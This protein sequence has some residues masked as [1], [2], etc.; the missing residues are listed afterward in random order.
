MMLKVWPFH[1]FLPL[2]PPTR[3]PANIWLRHPAEFS[4]SHELSSSLNTK[5]PAS[6]HIYIISCPEKFYWQNLLPISVEVCKYQAPHMS[7]RMEAQRAYLGCGGG[8][9]IRRGWAWNWGFLFVCSL[10]CGNWADFLSRTF[11]LSHPW[12]YISWCLKWICRVIY[13]EILPQLRILWMS[14]R[15]TLMSWVGFLKSFLCSVFDESNAM[16]P[17]SWGNFTKSFR[18]NRYIWK[19]YHNNE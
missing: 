11:T 16:K 12:H 4:T 1:L 9:V 7:N 18:G 14:K 17:Q 15:K 2:N 5:F 19:F 8:D 6:M 3:Q 10:I 13:C